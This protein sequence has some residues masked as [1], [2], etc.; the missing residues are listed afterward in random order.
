MP[1]DKLS[2]LE[3][4]LKVANEG[5]ATTKEVAAV[6]VQIIS[7]V[8]DAVTELFGKIGD[9]QKAVDSGD[10]ALN[11]RVD[12]V[13][14]SIVRERKEIDAA[15][16]EISLTPGEP[17]KDADPEV[18]AA[19]VLRDIELP[20]PE[21]LEPITPAQ[22]RYMLET[23]VG[24]ER[25]DASAIKGI[26]E[27]V[28]SLLPEDG[29]KPTWVG[30][31][32][33]LQ[34]T[35]NGKKIG[36][37]QYIDYEAGT[38]ITIVPVF[39]NGVLTLTVNSTGAAP[40]TWHNSEQITLQGDGKTFALANAPTAVIFLYVDRQPQIYV[41]D[42]TGNINGTNKTFVFTTLGTPDPSLASQIYATYL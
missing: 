16:R 8:R 3:N 15:I 19:M 9:V 22:I 18:V 29:G 7:S 37:V 25:L 31:R 20:E 30:G 41:L 35:V 13:E 24:R 2:R 11:S 40:A 28:K 42:Y 6:A 23:L 34:T 14:V 36:L 21:E 4:L 10:K 26:D 27:L 33:G 39:K 5:Y 38:N 12:D 17:G 1:D 32:T